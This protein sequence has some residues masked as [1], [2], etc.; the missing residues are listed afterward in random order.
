MTFRR[1][2]SL[3]GFASF[4]A[5]LP[6][7]LSP[8]AAVQ[9][10]SRAGVAWRVGVAGGGLDGVAL[11]PGLE[12]RGGAGLHLFAALD[13]FLFTGERSSRMVVESD[14]E[15]APLTRT[16]LSPP[17][18]RA[19]LGWGAAETD[20]AFRA[21]VGQQGFVEGLNPLV[22]AGATVGVGPVGL[23][24]DGSLNRGTTFERTPSPFVPGLIDERA[25]Q[26]TWV[27]R[28][29]VSAQADAGALDRRTVGTAL[30]GA[31]A[32]VVGGLAGGLAG[33]AIARCTGS[34]CAG[35]FII[36]FV[37]GETATIPLGVHLAE[38]R[39]GSYPAAALVSA[40]VAAAGL[41]AL[42]VV[43]DSG[44]AAQGVAVLV[45]IAQLV[46]SMAVE[47]RIARR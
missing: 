4:L 15:L 11:V 40:G 3:T 37:V 5:L 26:R 2:S 17:R 30:A 13:V 21:Y 27:P 10:Q 19:G 47:R 18:L 43:G 42:L 1:W 14:A 24:V 25:L 36:G 34:G 35:P 20:L 7:L 31:G 6:M 22:G 16:S 41:G 44:P 45:P 29:E 32:G 23:G 12:V 33:V 9:A 39:R 8:A 38:G 28:W 46:S